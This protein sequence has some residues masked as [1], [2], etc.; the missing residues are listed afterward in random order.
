V[1]HRQTTKYRLRNPFRTALVAV[2]LALSA[3][4]LCA[5]TARAQSAPGE[6]PGGPILVVVNDADVA[7]QF[8]RY[9]AEMLRAEGLNEFAVA[10]VGALN[11]G[12]LSSYQVVLLAETALSAGQASALVGWVNGG[13]NLIAMRPDAQLAGLLGLETV[14]TT[15][16]SDAYLKIDVTRPPGTGIV[17][18]TIQFHGP[19]D[20]YTLDGASSVATLYQ[21]ASGGPSPWPAVTLRS[22]GSAGGQAA[23]FTYDL[24]RSVVYTRQGNPLWAGEERDGEDGPIRSD[25]LFFG[26]KVGDVKPD[27]VDLTKVAIPQ[28]DEQ[29]RL[30]ANLITQMNI[31]RTPLP[32]FWYLP[33]GEEAAVVMTGDDHDLVGKRGTKG[34]FAMFESAS[35]GGCSPADWECVRSTSYAYPST[36]IMTNAEAGAYKA[37]GFEVALHL[38][39]SCEDFD[40]AL[41]PGELRGQLDDFKLV[42]PSLGSPLTNRTHCIAWSDWAGEPR[43]ELANGIRFDTN[44]YYWPGSWVNNRP[45][46]FTGSGFPMRFAEK[47]GSLIDVYQA[48]TQLT[49]ELGS[50]PTDWAH[51]ELHIRALLKGALEDGYYGVFTTNMHTDYANHT[52]ANVIVT[53]A[54]ARGV[55]VVSA[56]QMLKWLDGRN[57]SSFRGLSY[58]GGRL[59]FTV[60]AAEGSQGLEAMVPARSATGALVGLTR[61]GAVVGTEI[62]TV[63]GIEYAVFNAAPG[64]Y[65]ATYPAPPGTPP[66]GGTPPADP[67]D[68]TGTPPTQP[69]GSGSPH[70]SEQ[71][72][73]VASDRS[74]PRVTIGRR[75]MRASNY[76][77][78]TLRVSCPRTEV[79]CVLDLRLL[80]G[81][82][83]VA[84]AKFT[85]AGGKTAK[86]PL[87]LSRATRSKLA[88]AG[89]LGLL[90]VIKA[91]DAAGNRRTTKTHVRVLAP[92]W[93]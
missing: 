63:K 83:Q 13:G 77:S 16:L 42:W 62:R 5:Q 4:S 55:P 60:E 51:V 39:T 46:M 44:Y 79:R 93:R 31:D 90:T 34:Q 54:L 30:L 47:D 73:G 70:D 66:G 56:A 36:Q 50:G 69:D 68:G 43:A 25:D 17:G 91:R 22:V 35:P 38:N 10:D 81:S 87:R 59:G 75:T 67:T 1:T 11:A 7:N 80:R 37:R 14:G 32:R 53:E 61:N 28:A 3:T 74:A 57:G 92:G 40:P 18:D 84:L 27:W 89:S 76:G 82:K 45:G 85:V 23:A 2:L 78:V 41:L 49:D 52:G 15:P 19:A 58:S 12:L 72:P 26:A 65:A 24:A 48:T 8:G 64:A 88:R 71:P 6:G 9:Y 20:R 33:R 21:S 86:V 29:Q